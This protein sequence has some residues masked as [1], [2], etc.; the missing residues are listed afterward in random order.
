MYR[1]IG[2]WDFWWLAY[3]R[4]MTNAIEVDRSFVLR[5][6]PSHCLL[7]IWTSHTIT[8]IT[9]HSKLL[10]LPFEVTR[11]DRFL[12]LIPHSNCSPVCSVGPPYILEKSDLHRLTKTWVK[13]VPRWV[14]AYPTC[15]IIPAP[16]FHFFIY[17]PT[18]FYLTTCEPVPLNNSNIS[19]IW[20]FLRVSKAAV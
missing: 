11:F 19:T 20:H 14:V 8:L 9:L 13:F 1:C 16:S 3:P 12:T 18:S 5:C 17:L 4:F 7:D 10:S 15:L 2:C 6:G